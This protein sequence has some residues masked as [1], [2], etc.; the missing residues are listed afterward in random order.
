MIRGRLEWGH[1]IRGGTKDELVMLFM[2]A[3]SKNFNFWGIKEAKTRNLDTENMGLPGLFPIAGIS[4]RLNSSP[5]T[6]YK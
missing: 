1:S 4:C 6:L 3:I 5:F 2:A